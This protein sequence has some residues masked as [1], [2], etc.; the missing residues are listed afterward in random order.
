MTNPSTA[1]RGDG[2]IEAVYAL[3]PVQ[4]G[5]LYH[6][7]DAPGSGV[8]VNQFAATLRG[9]S[10]DAPAF[11]AAWAAVIARHSALRTLFTWEKRQRPLQLVRAVVQ[12]PWALEDWRHLSDDAQSAQFEAFLAADRARGFDLSKAPLLR[13][14]LIRLAD[15]AYRFLWTTHHLILDGWSSTLVLKEA[16]ARYAG[17]SIATPA[18]PFQE[19]VRWLGAQDLGVVESFWRRELQGLSAATP[20]D[21]GPATGRGHAQLRVTLDADLSAALARLAQSQRVTL[22][23]VF[24]ATWALLL[25][26]IS[27]QNEVLFGV[28][29][30]GRPY[31]LPEV[32]TRVGMFIN[33]LPLRAPV[34]AEATVADWLRDLQTRGLALREVEHTPLARV[35]GWSDFRGSGALFD[36]VLVF[37]NYPAAG[38]LM[39]PE[40]GLTLAEIDQREQSN[41]PLALLVVPDAG[42][43][44]HLYLIHDT[45]RYTPEAVARLAAHLRAVLAGL[46]ANPAGRVGALSVLDDAE[47]AQLAGFS[48]GLTLPYPR[49]LPI[50]RLIERWA[51][52][53][54]EAPAVIAAAEILTHA[55]LNRRANR[56]ARRL[57][58][59]GVGPGICV[60]LHVE[61]SPELLVGLLAI[62]KAGGAYVPLDPAYPRERLAYMLAE[63]AA[64]VALTGPGLPQL[65]GFPGLVLTLDPL[66]PIDPIDLIDLIDPIDPIGAIG[67]IGAAD[68]P[69]HANLPDG[70]TGDDLAYVIFTSGSTGLPKGV[71]VRHRQLMHSTIARFAI[72]P[73][74]ADRYLLLSSFSF[75]SSVPG[76][77]WPL[78]QG[79]AVCLPAQ[80]EEQ[81]ALAILGLI[82]RWSVTHTLCLPSLYG[83]LLEFATP[84]Q[85][86]SLR[87]VIVAGESCPPDL[88]ARHAQAAPRATLYNEYGPTEGTVWASVAE[89]RPEHAGRV[90]IGG[91]IPN[92]TLLVL[93]AQL[94]L[95]PIGVAGQLYIVG[96]GVVDGYLK[97]PDLTAERFVAVPDPWAPGA[98]LR[99]YATGDLARWSTDGRLDFLGRADQQVKIRG[100]R[101]ELEEIETALRALPGVRDAAVVARAAVRA[102]LTTH[103]SALAAALAALDGDEAEAVLAEIE[104]ISD[105]EAQARAWA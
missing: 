103:P 75:D 28:T 30:A 97:R 59:V 81:D 50:H 94:S 4:E 54:P 37:E 88:P 24:Q 25:G 99:A 29:T 18:A 1:Q 51:E 98:T 3:T 2:N 93:D 12:A 36:S 34:P 44:I 80:R 40:T 23:T 45:A 43:G 60:G 67:A 35:R 38:E 55:E 105:E 68:E 14:A 26:R 96:D 63:A 100:H 91:P 102:D 17:Q 70:A 41:Y 16:L 72:Y 33:T 9:G 89:I 56:L 76:L 53:T 74:Q 21:L 65:V 5:M 46:A 66:D 48:R 58:A 20:I 64:P 95:A 92:T 57:R 42:S 90:S 7:I 62:L 82:E 11:Q 87:A 39:P 10:L 13:F 8:Y 84:A 19:H 86:A 27:G 47:R 101:I 22:N 52:E 85:L 77:F 6:A 61:R 31:A 78:T 83:L 32:E 73:E 79:G 104:F 69:D 49:E 71:P 15:D